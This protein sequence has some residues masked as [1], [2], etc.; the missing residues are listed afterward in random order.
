MPKNHFFLKLDSKSTH[1]IKDEIEIIQS[2]FEKQQPQPYKQDNCFSELA[3]A[4][5]IL[6]DSCG[7]IPISP[8]HH[9]LHIPPVYII[10]KYLLGE[11][12]REK[13]NYFGIIGVTILTRPIN[14]ART[15]RS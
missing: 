13:Q 3:T 4:L 9:H 15:P 10:P 8:S 6:C 2:S 1:D 5:C 12:K 7:H 14:P 11:R